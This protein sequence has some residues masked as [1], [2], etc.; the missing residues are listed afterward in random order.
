MEF[1][2][3]VG[4]IYVPCWA[5]ECQLFARRQ[6]T[7]EVTANERIT[8]Y[9]AL[10]CCNLTIPLCMLR[11]SF[12]SSPDYLTQAAQVNQKI[13]GSINLIYFNQINATSFSHI[14]IAPSA[15]RPR[16]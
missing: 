4:I 9:A 15:F 7:K 12:G 11:Q 3:D 8:A 13:C 1:S 10:N 16:P 5:V 6:L 2:S 14:F